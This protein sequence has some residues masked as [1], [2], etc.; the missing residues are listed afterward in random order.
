MSART[1]TGKRAPKAGARRVEVIG[2]GLRLLA[3]LLDGVLL[4]LFTMLVLLVVGLVGIFV[5][6]YSTREP[7]RVELWF[8]LIGLGLSLI[9]YVAAWAGSGQT[10]G[11]A[12][13]GIRVVG[14]DGQ[15]LSVGRAL[16]RYIGYLVS[17]L[18]L[19]LG[20]LWIALDRK[21]QGWHDKLAGS[22]VVYSDAEFPAGRAVSFVAPASKPSWGWVVL[23]LAT[24]LVAPALL[25]GSLWVLG[26]VVS[27]AFTALFAGLR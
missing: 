4:F 19:S 22:Y 26:P 2:F 13:A 12:V 20:F 24:A 21:R 10:I 23:W 9:Y 17:G 18:A 14:A 7:L 1:S 16:L 3:T 11:K 25:L 5:G 27:T 8:T 15:S 6:M